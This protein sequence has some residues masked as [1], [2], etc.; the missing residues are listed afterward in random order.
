M[1]PSPP[2]V[3]SK[4]I[5]SEKKIITDPNFILAKLNEKNNEYISA[6]NAGMLGKKESSKGEKE[7]GQQQQLIDTVNTN[8]NE[9]VY[10]PSVAGKE[11]I[12]VD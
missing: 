9:T 6:F 2:K 5:A 11:S 4:S 3:A 7:L 8:A 1:S 10:T 12:L